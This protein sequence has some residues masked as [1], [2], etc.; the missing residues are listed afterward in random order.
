MRS[1]RT[2]LML[3]LVAA[4]IPVGMATG[5]ELASIAP[6]GACPVIPGQSDAPVGC[7]APAGKKLRSAVL[8]A[9][10]GKI[11][12]E[13]PD[14]V[15]FPGSSPTAG[16]GNLKPTITVDDLM[17][18]NGRLA[19]DVWRLNAGDVVN[20]KLINKLAPGDYAAT[21]LHTHG[22]LVSPDLATKPDPANP[23][24]TIAAEPVGDTVYV[25]T[26]PSG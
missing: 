9:A 17:L 3:A 2:M 25:C 7:E 16:S 22:L 24:E 23:A 6:N 20:I 26:V 18:F 14:G 11:T 1:R 10:P 12:F 15:T 4:S 8:T 19:N 21:N 13:L 5:A